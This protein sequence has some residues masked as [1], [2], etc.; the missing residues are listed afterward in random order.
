MRQLRVRSPANVTVLRTSGS[1]AHR[2]EQPARMENRENRLVEQMGWLRTLRL[3]S[4][5][6]L[7][8]ACWTEAVGAGCDGILQGN[9]SILHATVQIRDREPVRHALRV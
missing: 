8:L 9:G 4:V 6:T 5:V 1:G 2:P 3:L 7:A